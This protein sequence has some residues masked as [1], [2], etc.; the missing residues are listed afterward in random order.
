MTF[1]YQLSL[2]RLM[3]MEI[4]LDVRARTKLMPVLSLE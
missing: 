3:D 1:L 4:E 2:M